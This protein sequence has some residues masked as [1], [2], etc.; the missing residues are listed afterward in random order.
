MSI[1]TPETVNEKPSLDAQPTQVSNPRRTTVRSLVQLA[2]TLFTAVPAIVLIIQG[3]VGDEWLAAI[4]V[5][6]LAVHGAIVRFFALPGVNA[7]ITENVP[8][9]A[10]AKPVES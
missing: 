5:Q 10:P 7:W 9:L 6:V 4:L 3:I 1:P 2:L 8:W